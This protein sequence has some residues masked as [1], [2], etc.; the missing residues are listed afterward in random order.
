[1]DDQN[2]ALSK[3]LY[4]NPLITCVKNSHI[5]EYDIASAH[6]IAIKF[7]EGDEIYNRLKELPKL[8][9]NIAIGKM[10]IGNQT[11]VK[12]LQEYLFL[13]KKEFIVRNKIRKNEIIETT[14]DS[15]T[16]LNKI[17]TITDI[18]IDKNIVSFVNKEGI[19]SSYYR[20]N[21]KSV[22]FDA[23]AKTIKVKGIND[24]IINNSPFIKHYYIPLL[25]SLETPKNLDTIN[26]MKTIKMYRNNY[27]DTEN[28]DIY[29]SIDNNNHFIY[30]INKEIIESDEIIKDANLI[31]LDN[32]KVYV[33]P[34]FN[35]VL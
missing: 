1:M 2:G 25:Q 27:I 10:Q 15:I 32:Y 8:E 19:F 31:T 5:E 7:I 28:I 3:E 35:S 4:K 29:R 22:Y 34:I 9:R 11:L 33:M 14:K 16:I 21:G 6:L 23:I 12:Q 20:I 13:F 26:A 24:D 18:E 30:E 17:P